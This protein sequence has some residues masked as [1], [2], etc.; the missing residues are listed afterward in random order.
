MKKIVEFLGEQRLIL[1]DH[2]QRM[3]EGRERTPVKAKKFVTDGSK[4]SK[5]NKRWRGYQKRQAGKRFKKK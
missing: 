3:V 1:S 2:L 5:P 4:K